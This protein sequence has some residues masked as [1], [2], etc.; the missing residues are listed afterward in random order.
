M[1]DER[2]D[3]RSAIRSLRFSLIYLLAGVTLFAFAVALPRFVFGVVGLFLGVLAALVAFVVL[4]Y[5]PFIIILQWSRQIWA[6]IKRQ[7]NRGVNIDGK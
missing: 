2:N 1:S 5:W 7:K 3:R 4:V 6:G